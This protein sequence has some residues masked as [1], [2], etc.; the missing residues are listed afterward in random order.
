MHSM[1]T[2]ANGVLEK[3]LARYAAPARCPSAR[4]RCNGQPTVAVDADGDVPAAIAA[5]RA[6]D[7]AKRR[8]AA[9][10]R[11]CQACPVGRFGPAGTEEAGTCAH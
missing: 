5:M 9:R 11:L 3:L 6:F 4:C 7:K 1:S 10:R 8:H 2:E